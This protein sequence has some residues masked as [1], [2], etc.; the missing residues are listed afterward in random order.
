MTPY[1]PT[2][3]RLFHGDTEVSLGCVTYAGVEFPDPRPITSA[4]S[5]TMETVV[6]SD[7]PC[8]F[9]EDI[10]REHRIAHLE[11]T[12]GHRAARRFV[13]GHH[14]RWMREGERLAKRDYVA[15]DTL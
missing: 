15:T 1:D 7:V 9:W 14:T 13:N 12:K 11:W 5:W 2:T 4:K 10:R 6:W 3:L 8:S